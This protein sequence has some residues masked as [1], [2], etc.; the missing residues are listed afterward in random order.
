M[1]R[2]LKAVPHI[3]EA[4]HLQPA[5][6]AELM[7]LRSCE[8]SEF[9]SGFSAFIIN[10][11]EDFCIKEQWM[12]SQNVKKISIYRK[13]HAELLMLLQH[14]QARVALQDL[15]LGRKIVDMLPHWYL[16]HCFL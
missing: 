6:L 10:L 16:R 2:Q 8:D 15:Q 7:A 9:E 3:R 13:S 1:Q 4:E 14:A 5:L 12:A 11:R